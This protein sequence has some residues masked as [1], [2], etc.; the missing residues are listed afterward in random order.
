MTSWHQGRQQERR[1]E[2]V[3]IENAQ[4]GKFRR[5]LCIANLIR[6]NFVPKRSFHRTP[7]RQKFTLC[8]VEKTRFA[9]R[10]CYGFVATAMFGFSRSGLVQLHDRL[11]CRD[12][13]RP[14]LAFLRPL[15]WRNVALVEAYGCRLRVRS[16]SYVLVGVFCKKR[17]VGMTF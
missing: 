3:L 6:R 8:I 11:C 4:N 2:Q 16:K 12:R 13:R 9:K 14:A 5:H 1:Y 17:E 15:D 7:E 10:N